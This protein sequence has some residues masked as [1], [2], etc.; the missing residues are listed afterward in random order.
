MCT[1]CVQCLQR[2]EKGTTFITGLKDSVHCHVDA[3]NQTQILCKSS[4][5]SYH[6]AILQDPNFMFNVSMVHTKGKCHSP[7]R[8]RIHLILDDVTGLTLNG[9]ESRGEPLRGTYYEFRAWSVECGEGTP[10]SALLCLCSP[11]NTERRAHV[12]SKVGVT[13]KTGEASE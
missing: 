4:K 3:A 7:S 1:I 11:R 9:T 13:A 10:G 5:Y 8:K 6:G 2:P 12:T